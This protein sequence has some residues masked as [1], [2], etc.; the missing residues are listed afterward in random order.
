MITA[1]GAGVI[2]TIIPI[3]LLILGFEI[4]RAP[5]LVA[6]DRIGTFGLWLIG[7]V[8]LLGLVL[9]FVAEWA[10]VQAVAAG[11]CVTGIGAVLVWSSLWFVGAGS[12]LLLLG[13]LSE[14]LGIMERMGRKARARIT[15]SERRLARSIA[16][17]EKHHPSARRSEDE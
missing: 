9:G 2:A 8:L 3:G 4:Q 13:S 5:E 6:T 1:E 7:A 10:L 14:R 17:V 11:E 12:F 16:Y 15:A